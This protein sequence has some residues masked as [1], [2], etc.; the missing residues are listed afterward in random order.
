[1]G[2]KADYPNLWLEKDGTRITAQK[3]INS[4][5]EALLT[6]APA[7]TIGAGK[8]VSLS[9]YGSVYSN[10]GANDILSI[11][12]ASA[13]DSMGATVSGSFPISG[14]L[15]SF[16]TGYTVSSAAF[17]AAGGTNTYTVGDE[18]VDVGSFTISGGIR[19]LSF[20]KITLKEVGNA[21]LAQVLGDVYLEK[22]GVKVSESTTLSA[23]GKNVTFV[24]A[25]GG[26]TI[27]KSD[28]VTFK[29]KASVI[30]RDAS[31]YTVTLRLNKVED[32]V[33]YEISSGYS[34]TVTGAATLYAYT[35]NAGDLTVSKA[36][37]SPTAESYVKNAKNV[38]A[39]IANVRANQ[40][41]SADGVTLTVSDATTVNGFENARL[42]VNDVLVDSMDPATTSANIV[43]NSAVSFN[44][45]N[46]VVKVLVDVKNDATDGDNITF[47]LTG[48]SAFD[49]PV[50]AND[51]TATVGGS[52]TAA[53][54]TVATASLTATRSDG[55]SDAKSIVKG[56]SDVVLGKFTL[57]AFN[58]TITVNSVILSALVSGTGTLIDDADV[59]NIKV[60]VD[61]AQVGG[62]KNFTA[63]G[64]TVNLGSDAIVIPQGTTKV[65]TVLGTI[66]S[67]ASN[68][69]RLET[70]VSFNGMD[71]DGKD[72]VTVPS[73]NTARF[74][75]AIS[76]TLYAVKDGDTM[77]AALLS[78]NTGIN[79]V[80]KFKLTATNDDLKINKIYVSNVVAT[81]SDN[82]IS[83]INLYNGSTLLGTTVPSNGEAYYDLS[84]NPVTVEANK[85]VVLTAKVDLNDITE[86]SQSG[87]KVKLALTGISANS[88]SGLELVAANNALAYDDVDSFTTVG[89]EALAII[90]ATTTI[91]IDT[92]SSPVLAVGNVIKIEDEQML[93]NKIVTTDTVFEVTRGINGTAV[94][95]HATHA[96]NDVSVMSSISA[97]EF[98]IRKTV[99]TISLSSLPSTLLSAGNKTISK[100]TVAA[101]FNSDV[102]IRSFIVNVDAANVALSSLTGSIKVNGVTYTAADSVLANATTTAGLATVKVNVSTTPIVVAAG[103]S[104]TIEVVLNVGTPNTTGGLTASLVSSIDADAEGTATT[105]GTTTFGW[106][107]GSNPIGLTMANSFEVKGLATDTQS[108][109]TN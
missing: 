56:T 82:R 49:T 70:T 77:V 73:A 33:I 44:Q 24:L 19:D 87:L 97:N 12:S 22:S 25:D 5:N 102:T 28:S 69:E 84:S 29:V 3:S 17:A 6:I 48:A 9:V 18:A 45:G 86:A 39:L 85:S 41:F 104:K 63:S 26:L 105:A 40:A 64:A 31:N 42:Y 92:G 43:Y 94:V 81:S 1:L 109:T 88:S 79:E 51:D 27:D 15:M 101:D 52:A 98:I 8:T 37:T 10:P 34:A 53:K 36:T 57:K 75:I 32:L 106:S 103:K 16:T 60:M 54:I 62:T 46:N 65:V 2:S 59:S 30:D 38:V 7:L 68:A 66:E 20:K 93:I 83:A 35:L 100:F 108:L 71:A 55:Y 78:A 67:T 99:P 76:G 4:N 91:S 74:T 61:G 21:D 72:I 95:A 107:D 11:A 47:V 14:N 23:D 50:F 89:K 90:A 58:D 96:N 13:I 80:A